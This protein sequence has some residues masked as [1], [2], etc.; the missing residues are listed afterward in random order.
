MEKRTIIWLIGAAGIIVA[1]VILFKFA[2]SWASQ[3]LQCQ[4]GECAANWGEIN[5]QKTF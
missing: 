4:P 1:A 3:P 2:K 5:T